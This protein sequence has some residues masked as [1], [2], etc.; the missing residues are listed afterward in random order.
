MIEFPANLALTNNPATIAPDKA[1]AV[2]PIQVPATVTPGVYNLVVRASAQIPF[3]KDPMAKDKPAINIVQPVFPVTLTVAP[4]SLGTLTLSKADPMVKVGG[5]GEIM[6][7]V[8]RLHGFAGEYKV[9]VVVPPAVKGLAFDPLVI[10]AGKDEGKL[11][12]KA[13]ANAMPGNLGGLTIKATAQWTPSILTTTPAVPFSV[14][15]AK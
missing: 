3:N 15:V 1:E 14:N 13:A 9:E 8:A 6:V 10:P 7:K 12:I 5:Q 2:I 4:A 11:V